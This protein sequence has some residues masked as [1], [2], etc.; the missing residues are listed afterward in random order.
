[1]GSIDHNQPWYISGEK[2]EKNFAEAVTT[3][4]APDNTLIY[5]SATARPD[6]ANFFDASSATAAQSK[7]KRLIATRSISDKQVNLDITVS[8]SWSAK[9]YAEDGVTG[10]SAESQLSCQITVKGKGK[11]RTKTVLLDKFY[12]GPG[13]SYEDGEGIEKVVFTYQ[14][15]VVEQNEPIYL[16]VLVSTTS[17]REKYKTMATSFIKLED[18]NITGTFS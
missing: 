1:M 4:E 18:V 7:T 14:Q 16:E 11:T 10:A 6:E 17:K 13:A 15:P 5:V 3:T 8:Y 12:A 2:Q 9:G